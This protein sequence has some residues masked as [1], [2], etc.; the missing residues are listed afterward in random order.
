MGLGRQQLDLEKPKEAL[1]WFDQ[2]LEVDPNDVYVLNNKGWALLQLERLEESLV[3][4]DKALEVDPDYTFSLEN[5]V[6][7]LNELGGQQLD[8][9]KPEEALVWFDKA[10]EVDPN[11]VYVLNNK[12]VALYRLGQDVEATQRAAKAKLVS[13]FFINPDR[14]FKF[15]QGIIVFSTGKIYYSN[16]NQC[17]CITIFH[18][19][20]LIQTQR[21]E[22]LLKWNTAN[23]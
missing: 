3:W 22:W 12:G 7:A 15:M 1:V 4:F 23:K 8:L 21:P 20:A 18:V 2:A 5:K 16:I 17:I 6:D 10:L 13:G 14:L 19:I 11:D 9:E